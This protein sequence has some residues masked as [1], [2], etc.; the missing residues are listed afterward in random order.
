MQINI[1]RSDLT[2]ILD[3]SADQQKRWST[4]FNKR[5]NSHEKQDVYTLSSHPFAQ[6]IR[7]QVD[8]RLGNVVD[9]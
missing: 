4:G 6:P 3:K 2:D 9:V 7:F 8:L 1:F 5:Q